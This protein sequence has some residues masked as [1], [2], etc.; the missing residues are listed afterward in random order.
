MS[1]KTKRNLDHEP[2]MLRMARATRNRTARMRRA[3]MEQLGKE[4]PFTNRHTERA[5]Y[6]RSRLEFHRGMA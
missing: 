4:L 6:K 3:R 1:R 5:Y 2:D